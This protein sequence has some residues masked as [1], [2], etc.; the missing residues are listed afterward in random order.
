M[1]NIITIFRGILL[2]CGLRQWPLMGIHAYLV[3]RK[4]ETIRIYL[5]CFFCF[6]LHSSCKTIVGVRLLLLGVDIPYTRGACTFDAMSM[7]NAN[8]RFVTAHVLRAPRAY[9]IDWLC[10]CSAVGKHAHMLDKWS[11]DLTPL[12]RVARTFLFHLCFWH[13]IVGA[14]A[15]ITSSHRPAAF[16]KTE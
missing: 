11:Y 7:R 15:M 6:S 9:N 14:W 4:L 5:Y 3:V 13:Y 10:Q 16:F 12:N 8:A 2:R 1:K